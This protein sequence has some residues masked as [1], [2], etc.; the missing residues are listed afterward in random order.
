MGWIECCDVI[1]EGGSLSVLILLREAALV[2]A[3][4]LG[5][6]GF[7]SFSGAGGALGSTSFFLRG[8]RCGLTEGASWRVADEGAALRSDLPVRLVLAVSI[9]ELLYP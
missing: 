8:L 7:F 6:R 1:P 9:A 2:P 4:T 5:L 3:E